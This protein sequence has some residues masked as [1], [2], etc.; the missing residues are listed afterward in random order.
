MVQ[1]QIHTG[2]DFSLTFTQ[3]PIDAKTKRIKQSYSVILQSKH[4]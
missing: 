2:A 4:V 1:L 3:A